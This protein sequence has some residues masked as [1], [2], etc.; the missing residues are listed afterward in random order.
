MS[1]CHVSLQGSGLAAVSLTQNT[2]FCPK[3]PLYIFRIQQ[4]CNSVMSMDTMRKGFD[5]QAWISL[6]FPCPASGSARCAVV[7]LLSD[8]SSMA[9]TS[10]YGGPFSIL[11]GVWGK[12]KVFWGFEAVYFRAAGQ[13]PTGVD[14]PSWFVVQKHWSTTASGS[15][16]VGSSTPCLV[17]EVHFNVVECPHCGGPPFGEN[18]HRENGPYQFS[19]DCQ[20]ALFCSAKAHQ[21]IFWE[22]CPS[23]RAM[24]KL[25]HNP[26]TRVLISIKA[27]H[28]NYTYSSSLICNLNLSQSHHKQGVTFSV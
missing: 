3:L 4:Q 28:P 19:L 8:F 9:R 20:M 26:Q 23:F 11:V 16:G 1:S 27:A 13:P 22:A 12:M 21:A 6:P 18:K 14:S 7:S 2:F 17:W 10:W 15:A 25:G 5:F 24:E